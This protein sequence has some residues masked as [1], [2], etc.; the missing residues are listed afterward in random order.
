ML[1]NRYE[2]K[3]IRTAA[4]VVARTL[5]QLR[6]LAQIPNMTGQ[7]LAQTA[8]TM[9]K[10]A[11]CQS[12]FLHY[13]G[14]PAVLCVSIND[15]LVH[16]I[17]NDQPFRPGDL[18]TLDLGCKYR[19]YHADAAL[20][21]SIGAPSLAVKNLITTTQQSL[22]YVIKQ[23]KPGMKI[24]QI[25]CIIEKYVTARGYYLTSKYTGHGIGRQLHEFPP[26]FN[27]CRAQPSLVLRSGMVLCIEP[28]VLTDTAETIVEKDQWTVRSANRK[29]TCHFEKMV[30]ITENGAEILSDYA[31]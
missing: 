18:V 8:A 27:V 6:L 13:R 7:K 9:L 4:Q 12:N 20:S 2:I 19:N 30:L 5:E 16:G 1:K 24:N 10:A 29:L 26:I 14:F 15:Q 25:G 23:L 22:N 3:M 21:F 31:D 11:N 28:M 17:P